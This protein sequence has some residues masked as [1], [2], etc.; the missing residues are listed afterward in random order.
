MRTILWESF[1]GNQSFI[2]FA[3]EIA[4]CLMRNPFVT[5]GYAGAEYFCDRAQETDILRE[6]LLNENN[7]ALISP[8]R[9]G[10]KAITDK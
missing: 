4:N 3:A 1:Y 9:I 5:N 6:L 7:I 10:K 2:I 8:R